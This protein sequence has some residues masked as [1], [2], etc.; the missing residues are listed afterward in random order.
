M[1]DEPLYVKS[2]VDC[3]C[4]ERASKLRGPVEVKDPGEAARSMFWT[5]EAMMSDDALLES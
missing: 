1:V 5:A 2:G 3:R 4:F